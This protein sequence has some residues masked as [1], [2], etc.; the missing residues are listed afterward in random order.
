M[1]SSFCPLPHPYSSG[2]QFLGRLSSREAWKGANLDGPSG[3]SFTHSSFYRLNMTATQVLFWASAFPFHSRDPSL[4]LTLGS[5]HVWRK[6]GASWSQQTAVLGSIDNKEA[7]GAHLWI[8]L[9]GTAGPLFNWHPRRNTVTRL[10]PRPPHPP[11][12]RNSLVLRFHES[13]GRNS[14]SPGWLPKP[15][16]LSWKSEAELSQSRVPLTFI[17][18]GG[19]EWNE[20]L[21][22]M[23]IET[24][25]WN[26]ININ[27]IN[28][29]VYLMILNISVRREHTSL[30][31]FPAQLYAPR[32][33]CSLSH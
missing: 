17:M 19:E 33:K 15:H 8:D 18:Q 7:P 5:Q 13:Q 2:S 12:S 11:A 22:G 20:T 29:P 4:G 27:M 23:A 3:V 26:K 30:D 6:P 31:H 21:I 10:S 25:S 14:T 32:R 9:P 1:P 28:L 16:T 24:S